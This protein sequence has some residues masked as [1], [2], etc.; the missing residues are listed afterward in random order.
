VPRLVTV[1]STA[2]LYRLSAAEATEVIE[3]VA[4]ALRS[5]RDVAARSGLN[6]QEIDQMAPTFEQP[7]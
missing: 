2:S 6:R 3:E 4:D 1:R 7:Y 5:W